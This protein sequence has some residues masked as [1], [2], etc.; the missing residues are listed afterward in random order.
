[1]DVESNDLVH[2]DQHG[3]VVIPID[4]ARDIP[5]AAQKIINRE[6]IVLEACKAPDAGIESVKAALAKAAE[7]H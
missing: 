2:A 4:V 1:M 5:G 6:A 7:Y 3:A